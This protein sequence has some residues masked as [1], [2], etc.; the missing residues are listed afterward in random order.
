M[1]LL[2]IPCN[3]CGSQSLQR[4]VIAGRCVTDNATADET[5]GAMQI[6]VPSTSDTTCFDSKGITY[7]SEVVNRGDLAFDAKILLQPSGWQPEEDSNQLE[8]G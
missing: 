5:N 3:P 6:V 4:Q 7:G 1:L 8:R 2:I